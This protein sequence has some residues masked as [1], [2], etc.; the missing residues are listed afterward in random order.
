VDTGCFGASETAALSAVLGLI[1]V[2]GELEASLSAPAADCVFAVSNNGSAGFSFAPSLASGAAL[3]ASNST[4]AWRCATL[5]GAAVLWSG[6]GSSCFGTY[7]AVGAEGS[8][9]RRPT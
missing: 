6:F 3:D 1:S 7:S 9:D 4:A 8:I 5:A 2:T